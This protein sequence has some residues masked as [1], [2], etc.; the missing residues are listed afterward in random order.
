MSGTDAVS[1]CGRAVG[2]RLSPA[3]R[4]SVASPSVNANGAAARFCTTMRTSKN[5][6]NQL[7]LTGMIIHWTAFVPPASTIVGV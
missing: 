4:C 7:P 5:S 3:G 6:F 2:A 1:D